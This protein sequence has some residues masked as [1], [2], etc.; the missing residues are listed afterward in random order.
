M[1]T[2]SYKPSPGRFLISEPF[3]LDRNFQ[4]TVVL[5]VEHGEEGS[6]GFVMNRHL[7]THIDQLVE[8]VPTFSAPVFVGGPVEQQTLHYVHRL[9]EEL[10]GSRKVFQEVYWG[11]DF[12]V[13]KDKMRLNVISSQDILF[14]VGYSGWAPGQLDHELQQKSWIVAPEAEEFIFQEDYTDMWRQVLKSMG[15]KYQIISNYPVD[16]RLN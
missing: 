9:G 16:P 12:E 10:P 5:L 3:M 7:E 11:G 13:L 6:L 15:S 14:F 2:S 4:R 1:I 8:D